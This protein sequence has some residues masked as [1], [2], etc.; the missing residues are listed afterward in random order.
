MCVPASQD[1]RRCKTDAYTAFTDSLADSFGIQFE[2][3]SPTSVEFKLNQ[4]DLTEGGQWPVGD[5][6]DDKKSG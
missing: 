4:N 2:S 3:K 6:V 5:F 1:K